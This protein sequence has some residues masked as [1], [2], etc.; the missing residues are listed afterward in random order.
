MNET[1][2]ATLLDLQ[3]AVRALHIHVYLCAMN[4]LSVT[5]MGYRYQ[6]PR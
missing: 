1:C 2:S 5:D 3:K 4:A 6:F